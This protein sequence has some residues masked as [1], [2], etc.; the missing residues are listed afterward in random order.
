[1][2]GD[3][4]GTELGEQDLSGGQVRDCVTGISQKAVTNREILYRIVVSRG[5]PSMEFERTVMFTIT[6]N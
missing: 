1:M 4:L 6:N 3:K 2:R 5:T